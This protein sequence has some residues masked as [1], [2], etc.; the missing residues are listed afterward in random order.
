MTDART[1]SSSN[2]AAVLPSYATRSSTRRT[3]AHAAIS[4]DTSTLDLTRP[5]LSPT[6]VAK[7]VSTLAVQATIDLRDAL[8][9]TTCSSAG[10]L[11]NRRRRRHHHFNP[12]PYHRPVTALS[13][14]D[15]QIAAAL[16]CAHKVSAEM[17]AIAGCL[18]KL[19]ADLLSMSRGLSADY[20]DSKNWN[21]GDHASED[22][23]NVEIRKL[24]RPLK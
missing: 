2:A 19:T 14:L 6:K 5:A 7:Q 23:T 24:L 11:R 10:P 21:E 17:A 13:P 18:E 22:A 9:D 20:L 16:I 15:E 4:S 3:R 1:L 12:S 8:S